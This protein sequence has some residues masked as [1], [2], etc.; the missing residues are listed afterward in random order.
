MVSGRLP[1]LLAV[2]QQGD[3]VSRTSSVASLAS[4]LSGIVTPDI[5]VASTVF[6]VG[7]DISGSP[8]NSTVEL[9][10]Y[11]DTP[12][13]RYVNLGHLAPEPIH[14]FSG[15]NSY[16]FRRFDAWHQRLET[17]RRRRFPLLP[18]RSKSSNGQKAGVMHWSAA[19]V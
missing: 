9:S 8:F 13:H 14:V 11:V 17:H 7:V 3:S 18:V 12:R 1:P 10:F 19:D 15:S 5:E 16:H 2:E 6:V 4:L